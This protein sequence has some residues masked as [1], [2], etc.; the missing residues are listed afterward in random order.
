MDWEMKSWDSVDLGPSVDLKLGGSRSYP[1]SSTYPKCEK[2]SRI[3]SASSSKKARVPG[4]GGQVASCLVEGC[5]A[6]LSLCREYHRRHKV[7]EIHSKTPMVIVNGLEKRFCQQC[8]RFHLLAEFDEGKRSC[9]KRLDGHNRRR[10]KPPPHASQGGSLFTDFQDFFQETTPQSNWIAVVTAEEDYVRDR[11]SPTH[12][13]RS[14]PRLQEDRRTLTL[15]NGRGLETPVCHPLLPNINATSQSRVDR[16]F[17]NG[18]GPVLDSELVLSRLSTPNGRMGINTGSTQR[19]SHLSSPL[20]ALGTP[21][22]TRYQGSNQMSSTGFS[23]PG[24]M[25]DQ[26]GRFLYADASDGDVHF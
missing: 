6:D 26:E 11:S 7:C 23:Y 4:N 2:D 24:L 14:Y 19:S 13:R 17:H 15:A 12:Y 22:F 18:L 10:R 1:S 5:N 3:S 8:S 16:M 20:N 21:F 25:D 9:R